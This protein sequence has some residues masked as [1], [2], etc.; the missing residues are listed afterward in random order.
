MPP[1]APADQTLPDLLADTVVRMGYASRA[2]VDKAIE[3]CAARGPH[4][5]KPI[6]LGMMLVE[7]NLIT[8]GQWVKLVSLDGQGFKVPLSEDAIHIAARLRAKVAAGDRII[9]VCGL[10]G[11]EGTTLLAAQLGVALSLLGE[12]RVLLIDANL[13]GAALHGVFGLP[14]QPGL[15]DVLETTVD[16]ETA[17]QATALP[18]LAVLPA[19]EKESGISSV[20]VLHDAYV[21][22]L[23]RL[24]EDY[25]FILI[26]TPPLKYPDA[27]VIVTRTDGAV[28]VVAAPLR[29]KTEVL[30]T[31]RT[32]DGLR[33]KLFGY[34]LSE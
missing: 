9:S 32:L 21:N 11:E 25:R 29:R 8:P 17:I 33:V 19:G 26:D 13:R 31:K 14:R 6:T 24:R 7:M 30:E 1:A 10:G 23:A 15:L 18:N 2:D 16:I 12:G 22:L 27:P 4:G 3:A 34:A 20:V 28:L 5:E